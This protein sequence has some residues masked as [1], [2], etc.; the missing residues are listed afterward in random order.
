MI[1]VGYS[2]CT[3]GYKLIDLKTKNGILSRDVTFLEALVQRN[4]VG[5]VAKKEKQVE[6]YNDK[7][8]EK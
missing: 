1:F 8:P 2:D 6:N 3:K 4:K 5:N 7:V